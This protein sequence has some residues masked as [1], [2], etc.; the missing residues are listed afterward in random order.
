[1]RRFLMTTA[2]AAA[3]G[4]G[5][6]PAHATLSI[7]CNGVDGADAALLITAGRLPILA[8]VHA[9]VEADGV[10]YSTDPDRHPGATEIAFG[11]GFLDDDGLRADF[12]DPNITEIVLSLR[13]VRAYDDKAGAEAGVLHAPGVGAWP[14]VCISG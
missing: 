3:I 12:T 4:L 10:T 13:L 7:E 1:M 2:T 8:I 14:V 6:A 9:I 11:Q 5:V